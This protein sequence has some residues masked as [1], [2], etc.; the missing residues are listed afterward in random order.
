M[1]EERDILCA[2]PDCRIRETGK[3]V[4]GLEVNACQSFGRT[5]EEYDESDAADS[6][7][8]SRD[9]APLPLAEKLLRG[10]AASILSRGN[11]RVI[12]IVGP[13]DAG[14]TSLIAGLYDLFQQGGVEDVEFARSSTLHA[15]EKACHES[16]L[17]SQR[18]IADSARTRRG[19]VEFYHLQVGGGYIE[20]CIHL[21]LG[22]RAGEEYREA[23]TDLEL[24]RQLHEVKRADTLVFLVDGARLAN[25]QER[26]NVRSSL[27]MMVQALIESGTINSG[28]RAAFVLTKLDEVR[29]SGVSERVEGDFD[30]VV[31]SMRRRFGHAFS[32]LEGFMVAASPKHTTVDR[33]FG[34]PQ[35][36]RYWA[37]AQHAEPAALPSLTLPRRAFGRFPL[38]EG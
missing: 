17:A 27:L 2:N 33:G 14:K 5:A 30:D 6:A 29:A 16:R 32:E 19:E 31:R 37:V 26:H 3:C 13:S 23:V 38:Y 12:A 8:Q 22:D 15:F 34:L 4:E 18:N 25:L 24:L 36:L 1:S 21:L 10:V 11:S 7:G 35:L 28:R 9:V 20:G